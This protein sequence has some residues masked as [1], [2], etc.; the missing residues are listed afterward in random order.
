MAAQSQ[1]NDTQAI[2]MQTKRE[3]ERLQ[4]EAEEAEMSAAA[5]ASMHQAPPPASNGYPSQTDSVPAYGQAPVLTMGQDFGGQP[6]GGFGGA[7]PAAYDNSG[8]MGGGGASIPTPSG[9]DPYS[10]P[11]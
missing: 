8:V 4:N 5:A 2:A 1:A 6:Y 7:A 3:A 10:N 9:E 11:F